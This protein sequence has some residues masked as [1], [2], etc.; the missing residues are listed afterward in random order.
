MTRVEFENTQEEE[1]RIIPLS[2]YR[3][4]DGSVSLLAL[5]HKTLCSIAREYYPDLKPPAKGEKNVS[6]VFFDGE[7]LVVGK[8]SIQDHSWFKAMG[9]Q[10]HGIESHEVRIPRASLTSFNLEHKTLF[11]S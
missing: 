9:L 8:G 5:R 7:E 11:I 2:R 4:K 3:S 10:N 1:I 6:E